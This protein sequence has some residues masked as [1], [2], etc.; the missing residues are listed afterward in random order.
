MNKKTFLK[1]AKLKEEKFRAKCLSESH[2]IGNWH[3][4]Y[5]KASDEADKH[6]LRTG[7]KTTV[8]INIRKEM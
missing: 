5:Y 7:H 2:H 3:K 6:N 4:D 1:K 8:E